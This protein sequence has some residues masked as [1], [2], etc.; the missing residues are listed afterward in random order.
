MKEFDGE[1]RHDDGNTI[2]S[3]SGSKASQNYIPYVQPSSVEN[4]PMFTDDKDIQS[5]Q[6]VGNFAV[7]NSVNNA[8]ITEVLILTEHNE[9]MYQLD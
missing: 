3:P 8:E 7:M 5:A 2:G 6:V 1:K 4:E 9:E